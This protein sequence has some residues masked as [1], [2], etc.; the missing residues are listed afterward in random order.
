MHDE[1]S[2]SMSAPSIGHSSLAAFTPS[3]I[4]ERGCGAQVGG[5]SCTSLASVGWFYKFDCITLPVVAAASSWAVLTERPGFVCR[6][7]GV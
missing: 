3:A 6:Q 4:S 5:E 2:L 1:H 7:S